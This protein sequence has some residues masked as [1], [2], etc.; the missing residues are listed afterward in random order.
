MGDELYA[1]I[2]H[3]MQTRPAIFRFENWKFLRR[4]DGR[5]LVAQLA[6]DDQYFDTS[7]GPTYEI[8]EPE[9]L[10]EACQTI[11]LRV[12]Q[13]TYDAVRPADGRDRTER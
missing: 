2:C 11:A 7:E 3:V 4:H 9:K 5:Y 12:A 8:C 13:N 6:H 10:L 1:A